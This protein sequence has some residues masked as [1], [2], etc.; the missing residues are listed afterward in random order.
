MRFSKKECTLAAVI[1]LFVSLNIH[2]VP[3]SHAWDPRDTAVVY[4]EGIVEGTRDFTLRHF[5]EREAWLIQK[6]N[7]Y[8][9]TPFAELLLQYQASL[10]KFASY[11]ETLVK[12]PEVGKTMTSNHP[13]IRAMY[14]L[15]AKTDAPLSAMLNIIIAR[16]DSS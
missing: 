14:D 8:S 1:I 11:M 10:Q 15:I 2:S 4:A 13:K 3:K 5:K 7:E 9:D 16:Q 12:D 6:Q